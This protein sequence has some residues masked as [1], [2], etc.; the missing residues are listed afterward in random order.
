VLRRSEQ[1]CF[2]SASDDEVGGFQ[3]AIRSERSE[4]LNTGWRVLDVRAADL[5][6]EMAEH[7]FPFRQLRR[8]WRQPSE[9]RSER[10]EQS[11]K[12]R[13]TSRRTNKSG[14]E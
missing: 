5:Q 11:T 1:A 6:E 3:S 13:C 4:Q 2:S 7:A 12:A 10:S 9:H 8:R 14:L